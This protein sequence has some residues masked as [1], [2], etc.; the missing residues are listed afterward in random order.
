MIRDIMVIPM[1]ERDSLVIASDNSGGIGLKE[2]DL[3]HTPYD[4][5]SYFSLRVAAMECMAAG[6]EPFSVIIHNF[7]GDE[8]WQAM[9]NG[10]ERGL[11]ELGMKSLVQISGSTESNFPLLQSGFGTIVIGKRNREFTEKQVSFTKMKFA[12]IGSPLVGEEVLKKSHE[13]VPLSLFK[14]LNGLN[15]VIL[16]P[17]G[18]KG[19]LHELKVM[20]DNDELALNSVGCELDVLK[21]SGPS[22]CI[23]IAFPAVLEPVVKEMTLD[24]YH[25]L[26]IEVK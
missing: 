1:S 5:V 7:C 23:L 16:L 4:V 8:S 14:E 24:L 15:G 17:V 11:D 22:T 25:S 26:E 13:V 10:V 2:N 21:T 19:I 6:G 18:S 9:V 12:V 20:A 3:V